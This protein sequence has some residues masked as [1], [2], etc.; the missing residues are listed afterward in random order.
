MKKKNVKVHTNIE[1]MPKLEGII[2]NL[3][4]FINKGSSIRICSLASLE[5]I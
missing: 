1:N 5:Q 2:F 4:K 3:A